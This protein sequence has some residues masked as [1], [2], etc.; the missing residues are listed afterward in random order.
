MLTEYTCT[1]L[2][3]RLLRSTNIDRVHAYFVA[4]LFP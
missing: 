4:E 3:M 2:Q 1:L